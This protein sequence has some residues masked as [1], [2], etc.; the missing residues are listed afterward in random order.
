[1]PVGVLDLWWQRKHDL[2]ETGYLEWIV[3]SWLG[4]GGEFLF[5]CLAILIVMALAGFLR[6]RWWILGAPVFVGLVA[7]FAFVLPVPDSGAAAGEP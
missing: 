6:D 1:M 4:L 3:G 7:L 5:I 2:V